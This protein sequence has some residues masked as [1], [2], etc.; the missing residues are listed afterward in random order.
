MGQGTTDDG[1]GTDLVEPAGL[2][3]VTAGLL[4]GPQEAVTGEALPHRAPGPPQVRLVP[5]P[6][7]TEMR[8]CRRAKTLKIVFAISQGNHWPIIPHIGYPNY[9]RDSSARVPRDSSTFNL[10]KMSVNNT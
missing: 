10:L 9:L 5:R 7:N 8:F 6:S 3:P 4:A 1:L 2:D